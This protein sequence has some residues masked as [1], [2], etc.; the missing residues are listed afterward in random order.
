MTVEGFRPSSNGLGF[1]GR[2]GL[3]RMRSGFAEGV[4]ASAGGIFFVSR[5]HANS[6]TSRRGELG[7]APIAGPVATFP[8]P[9]RWP[10]ISREIEER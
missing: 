10:L 5:R 3:G 6:G 4:G 9:Q 1:V 7:F 8:R 2:V